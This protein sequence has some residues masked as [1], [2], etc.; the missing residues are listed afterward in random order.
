MM[1]A[2]YNFK[3]E[4]WPLP[5][6]DSDL[7]KLVEERKKA[8][9]EH[10]NVVAK[11]EESNR[12]YQ[13]KMQQYHMDLNRHQAMVQQAQREVYQHNQEAMAAQ[14]AGQPYQTKPNPMANL[15]PQPIAPV[16]PGPCPPAPQPIK[17]L[18]DP[19]NMDL[20]HLPTLEWLDNT[21]VAQN[22]CELCGEEF[23]NTNKTRDKGNHQV[24]SL[25]NWIL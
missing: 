13:E 9:A 21:K 5:M 25:T 16:A 19:T 11:H 1:A 20:T 6:K 3:L 23:I 7:N 2:E 22:V 17:P 14:M 15:P 12:L 24:S 10:Q 8:I 4:E 18:E